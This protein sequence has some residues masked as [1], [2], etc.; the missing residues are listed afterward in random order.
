MSSRVSVL[1]GFFALI[2]VGVFGEALSH[3]EPGAHKAIAEA[4]KRR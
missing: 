1:K 4:Q 2:A 3:V